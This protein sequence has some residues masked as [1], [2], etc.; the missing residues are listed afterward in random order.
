MLAARE[1]GGSRR[2]VHAHV[3]AAASEYVLHVN[4]NVYWVAKMPRMPQVA[5]LFLQESH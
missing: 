4:E 1:A 2:S 3:H 5:G